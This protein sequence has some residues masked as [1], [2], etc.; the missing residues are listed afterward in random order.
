VTASERPADVLVLFGITGDLARKLVLPALYRLVQRGELTVPVIG[1]ALT[2]LDEEGL[3]RHV[4]DCVQQAMRAEGGV[5]PTTLDK[6][7]A[8]THLVAGD[9]ADPTVFDRLADA[10]CTQAGPDAFAVYY[11]AVPPSLFGTVADGIAAAGLADRSRLVV[12][13]PFGHDLASARALND[14]LSRHYPEERVFRVDHFLGKEPVED[15]LVLRFANTLLEPLWNRQWVDHFEITMAEDF[16]VAGRGSFYDAVG[17]VRDVVQNHL[18]QVLA[19][20]LMEPPLSAGADDQ[21]N[22]KSQLLRAVRAVDPAEV[23][24]GRYDGYLDTPGVAAGSTT[25]TYVAMTLHVDNW[26]WADVPVYLRAGKALPSTLLDVVAVLRHPPQALF[27]DR[28]EVPPPN[29]VRLRLQPDPGVTFTLLA[30]QPGGANVPVPVPV[31]VDFRQELGPM[32]AAYERIFADA[33]SGD[34]AHFAR[35]DNLEQAWRIVGPILDA[36]TPPASYPA[37]TW[38]PGEAATLPGPRGWVELPA[39]DPAG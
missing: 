16:D 3:R 17:T 21:R 11:L 10:I 20:L 25:E 13:K 5:D 29:L 23:V 39:P 37:G 9:Y 18:L 30:K 12:E 1:V 14:R 8:G 2:D 24:R 26:R 33:L 7:V 15:L 34:P 4:A 38:G 28:G 22:A 36:R 27:T 32:H 6:M 35:M 19:Y 31:A